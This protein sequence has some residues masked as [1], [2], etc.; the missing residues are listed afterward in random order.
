MDPWPREKKVQEIGNVS[1]YRQY[2]SGIARDN[3]VARKEVILMQSCV[4]V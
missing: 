2:E 1:V 3:P 4:V